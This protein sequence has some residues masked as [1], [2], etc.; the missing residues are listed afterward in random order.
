MTSFSVIQIFYVGMKFR[1]DISLQ[2]FHCL[3]FHNREIISWNMAG[4]EHAGVEGGKFIVVNHVSE[5]EETTTYELA[6]SPLFNRSKNKFSWSGSPENFESFM[7]RKLGFSSAD[8]LSKT[9][10]GTC[11]VWKTANVTFNLYSKT[12]TLLFQGKAVPVQS[13]RNS[14][15]QICEETIQLD[16]DELA[17]PFL[18]MK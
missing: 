14:L 18:Q 7:L 13:T 1:E 8:I 4:V 16:V 5:T 3:L 15:R 9:S 17:P 12:K 2:V 11:T 6:E 10:N